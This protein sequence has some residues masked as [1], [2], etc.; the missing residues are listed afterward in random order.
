MPTTRG[1]PCD[2]C[3]V[4]KPQIWKCLQC[5]LHFCDTCWDEEKPHRPGRAGQVHEKLDTDV[6]SRLKKT[7]RFNHN[8]SSNLATDG[9]QVE[10]HQT[11]TDTTW[12]ALVKQTG[13]QGG[14]HDLQPTDRLDE[15]MLD[16]DTG[17]FEDRYPQLVSFVG[18]TGAGKSTLIKMLIGRSSPTDEPDRFPTPVSGFPGDCVPTSGDVH[19]YS[20]PDTNTGSHPILYADSE[21]L[22][23]GEKSP[24]ALEALGE[25]QP[26]MERAHRPR[27]PL[28]WSKGDPDKQSRQFAVMNLVPKI[29]Y[30]FSDVIV[31]VVREIK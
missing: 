18:R 11:D 3:N 23:G 24:R 4:P 13:K 21:G 2:E 9:Q 19:L 28:A 8:H 6:Y 25:T 15:I 26:D 29:L 22:S 14:C 31:F 20:D 27:I 17:L 1:E 5:D 7:F 30:T 16:S 10:L 12:F